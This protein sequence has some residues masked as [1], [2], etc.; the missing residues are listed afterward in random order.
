[1]GLF[2]SKDWNV[3]GVIFERADLYRINGNRGKGRDATTI[4]DNVKKHDRTIY[5]AV[6][7]QKG[8]LLEGEPGP[9]ASII[10]VTILQKLIRELHTNQTIRQILASLEKGESD[11]LSKPLTW[12]GYPTRDPL[13]PP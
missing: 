8:A 3:I 10:P 1:M 7:N 2:G 5:W 9:G 6:Y 4:R 11:K 12:T 13:P